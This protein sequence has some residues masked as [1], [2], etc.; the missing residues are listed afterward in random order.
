MLQTIY[1]GCCFLDS[2][3]HSTAQSL[4]TQ[5]PSCLTFGYLITKFLAVTMSTI[6]LSSA[7]QQPS[8]ANSTG[9]VACDLSK[10]WTSYQQRWDNPLHPRWTFQSQLWSLR[11]LCIP[12]SVKKRGGWIN[13]IFRVRLETNLKNLF[14]RRCCLIADRRCSDFRSP[15][16]FKLEFVGLAIESQSLFAAVFQCS[17]SVAVH[18]LS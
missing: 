16:L 3:C 12:Q 7:E 18:L 13:L 5:T 4:Y 14:Q 6:L 1:L 2:R 11:V 10:R 17:V 9:L 15:C 8:L